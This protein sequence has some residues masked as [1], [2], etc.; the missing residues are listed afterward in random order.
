MCLHMQT[1][2]GEM[3]LEAACDNIRLIIPAETASALFSYRRFLFGNGFCSRRIDDWQPE[4]KGWAGLLTRLVH[5][6]TESQYDDD[7]RNGAL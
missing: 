2:R 7:Q 5:S 3:A 1:G 6:G 4:S